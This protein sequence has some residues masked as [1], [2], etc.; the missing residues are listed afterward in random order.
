MYGLWGYKANKNDLREK[1]KGLESFKKYVSLSVPKKIIITYFLCWAGFLFSFSIGKL[2]LYISSIFKSKVITEPAKVAQTVGTAKFKAVSSAVSTTVGAKNAY[3][4]YSLSYIISNFL[5]CLIIIS[6]LGALAYL[7]KKDMENAKTP[8][9]KEEVIRNYQKYL[10][11][12]F[13]FTVINPLTGL[14]GINLDY[15]DLVA[16]IPHG[17]FEFMGFAISVVAGVELANKIFPI[18]KR[19]LSYKKLA[20]LVLASFIFISIAGFLEPIDWYIFEYAR[21]NNYPLTYAFITAYKHL[22]IYIVSHI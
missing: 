2:L 14:I 13:I 18:V 17:T 6:A 21:V 9:E 22:I 3:L 1:M 11:I 8:E 15:H 10:F 12:L 19:S 7:Y 20:L 5:G 16:V 4:T